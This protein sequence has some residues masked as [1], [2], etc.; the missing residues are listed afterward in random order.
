MGHMKHVAGESPKNEVCAL[1]T[2]ESLKGKL[3]FGCGH[4]ATFWLSST[5]AMVGAC[6]RVG[7][8]FHR[9]D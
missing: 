6:A 4:M 8:H 1:D 2:I 5:N 7:A 9:I 3:H